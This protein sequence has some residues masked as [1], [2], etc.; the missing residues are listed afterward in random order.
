MTPGRLRPLQRLAKGVA[1]AACL[2][3]TAVQAEIPNIRPVARDLFI[4]ATRWDHR[5]GSADWTRAAMSAFAAYDSGLEDMVPA[6]IDTF[7]PGYRSNDAR[8]RR[9]FWVGLMSNLSKIESNQNPQAVG[10]GGKWF[11]L[12]QISPATAAHH[13]CEA[14][15][16][17]ALLNPEANV[18]CAARI[19]TT[20]IR[21][22]GAIRLRDWGPM[23]NGAKV[24]EMAAWTREQ[25]YCQQVMATSPRPMA[26]PEQTI[27]MAS[28]N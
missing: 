13:R 10:G 5:D 17:D 3:A 22:D 28:A 4:P 1:V 2:L 14:R 27:V 23:H 6:N 9:A 25:S 16:G 11:G 7:C 19:F 8:L 26:R 24:A 21:N 18:A 20:S 15:S 12:M